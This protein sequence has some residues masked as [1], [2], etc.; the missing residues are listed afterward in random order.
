MHHQ[1]LEKVKG[2]LNNINR[3]TGHI[4]PCTTRRWRKL[5]GHCTDDINRYTGIFIHATQGPG[6]S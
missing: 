5:K 6:E 2:T 4:Q 3:Y 1:A